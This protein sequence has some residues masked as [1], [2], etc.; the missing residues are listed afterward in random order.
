MPIVRTYQCADC[1]HLMDITLRLEDWETPAPDCPVC[2]KKE[3]VRDFKPFAIG[4]SPTYKAAKMAERIAEEDYGVA[5]MKLDGKGGK[6]KIRYKDQGNPLQS[7]SWGSASASRAMIEQAI[8]IGKSTK[9]QTG[10]LDGLD[11]LKRNIRSGVETD[12]LAASRQRSL[13]VM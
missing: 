6:N 10:G 1:G 13:R 4:G 12:I 3:M 9:A 2:A 5:D 8:A 7:S 11:I